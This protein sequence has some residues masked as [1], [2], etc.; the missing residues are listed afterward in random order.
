MNIDYESYLLK[1]YKKLSLTVKEVAIE[2]SLSERMI[3]DRVRACSSE[4]PAFKK[5]GSK[6]IFPIKEVALFL[7]NDFVK[8]G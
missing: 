4:I 3:M 1:K 7:E 5:I 2:I 6:A 8:V